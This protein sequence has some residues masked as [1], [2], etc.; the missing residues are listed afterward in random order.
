MQK[1]ILPRCSAKPIE[2]LSDGQWIVRYDFRPYGKD[3][4]GIE[5]VSFASS[6]YPEKPT[7]QIIERSIRRYAVCLTM[8]G[9]DAPLG[10]AQ[11]DLS[12]YSIVD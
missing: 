4:N 9:E 1:N 10:V 3:E 12:I 8:Y 5:L 6:Q 11:P 2:Q 7:L